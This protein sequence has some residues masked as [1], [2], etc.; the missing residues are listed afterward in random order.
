MELIEICRNGN[1]EKINNMILTRTLPD[2]KANV[3]YYE[4]AL[5]RAS[6][7]GHVNILIA[8]LEHNYMFIDIFEVKES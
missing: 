3:Y 8:L 7:E 4:I 5:R 1:I 6:I 2:V